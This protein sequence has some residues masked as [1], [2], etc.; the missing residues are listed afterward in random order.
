LCVCNPFTDFDDIELPSSTTFSEIS[1]SVGFHATG[2]D[3][4]V[5]MPEQQ[6]VELQRMI[7]HLALQV[8][9]ILSASVTTIFFDR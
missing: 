8:T 6:F 1:S 4:V 9:N 3:G 5:T 2:E 7:Q